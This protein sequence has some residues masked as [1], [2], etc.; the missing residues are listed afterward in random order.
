MTT[1]TTRAHSWRFSRDERTLVLGALLNSLAFFAALPF[2][3][4]YLADRTDLS[5][6][7]IGAVVGSIP[8][9]AALGGVTGGMLADRWGSVRL[10]RVGLALNVAVYAALAFVSTPAAAIAL[11]PCLGVARTMVEPSMKKLLSLADTGDGRIFRVRYI[12]LCLGA[13]VGPALGG[14]LFHASPTAFFLVPAGCFALYLVVMVVRGGE[15]ARL[16]RGPTG[17]GTTPWTEALRDPFLV[18][19]IGAGAVIFLVFSQMDAAIPLFMKGIHGERTEYLFASLLVLNA[20]LALVVQPPVIRLSERLSRGPLATLGCVFFA[21]AFACVWL[22]TTSVVALYVAIVFWTLG[23]AILLPLPDIAVH[24]LATD[25]R[26]GTY[27]GLS[28]LRYLGFFV[29]PVLGGALLELHVPTYFVLMG[30]LVFLCVP[31]LLRTRA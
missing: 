2:A 4:L 25:E 11:L 21:L 12:T 20:V 6:A 17:S 24:D 7:W 1:P 26:K 10:M 29:G 3:A 22:G 27:F 13:I 30:V 14:V 31:L 19:A 16:E 8:M 5:A 18:A 9:I 23:E 28:E 15:L